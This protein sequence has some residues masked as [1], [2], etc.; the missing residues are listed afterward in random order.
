MPIGATSGSTGNFT[1]VAVNATKVLGAQ[2]TGWGTPT[3]QSRIASFPGASATLVQCSNAIAQIIADL[4][5]HG[6][7]GA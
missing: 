3:G 5:T 7:L 6:M 4:K 1:Q 2:I